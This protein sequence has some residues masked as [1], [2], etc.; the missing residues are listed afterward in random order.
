MNFNLSKQYRHFQRYQQIAQILLR[1]GLG[2]VIDWLDLK[3][4]LPF[5]KRFNIDEK[6]INKPTLAK[7]IRN[8]LQDLGPTYIKLGQLMS[9][10][11]DILSPVFIQEFRELQDKVP[12]VEFE[13]INNILVKELGENYE[14]YFQNISQ[15][16][17]AAASIAQTHRATLKD[18]TDVILKIQRPNIEDKI[19]IDLE[20]LYNLAQLTEERNIV[21]DFVRPTKIINEFRNSLFKELDFNREV[22]NINKFKNNFSD[23]P[24]IVVPEVYKELSSKKVIVMEE[25]KGIK[26]NQFNPDKYSNIKN[27]FL[28]ELGAKAFMKQVLIDGFFHADPHPGNIFIVDQDKLAYID[29][30]LMGQITP[31]IQTQFSLLFFALIRKNIN[32]I[33]DIIIEIGAVPGNINIRKLKLDIQDLINRYYGLD[34]G[35][36]NLM[37]LA[38]DF[39]RIVYKYHIR[40][41]EDFFLLIRALAVSEGVGYNIDPNFNIVDV[42]NDFLTEL[43]QY[44]VKPNNLIYQLLN[45]I[46]NF[47]NATKDLPTKLKDIIDKILKDN[48]TVNFKHMNLENLINKLDIISNRLSISLIISALIIGSSMILQTNMKPQIFNIPLFGFLGYIIAGV[49]GFFL[50]IAILRSGRF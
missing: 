9:T 8:V 37:S 17:Q 13:K 30:G 7:R 40:M 36:I 32:I 29:F 19:Q 42:G 1:N 45:K 43:L 35:E 20:I 39:Q 49:L 41:P 4:Y 33:V 16:S 27:D 22:A 34:L 5:K 38:D 47:R 21:P 23:N 24:N 25:I 48:F 18:G 10:R 14:K 11:P 28:A 2:F 31:E 15:L 3:K 44:R 46:W 50:V 6:N 12:P 26:L